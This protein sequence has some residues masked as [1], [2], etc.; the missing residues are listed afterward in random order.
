MHGRVHGAENTLIGLSYKDTTEKKLFD[1]VLLF[2]S[3]YHRLIDKEMTNKLLD[4][5]ILFC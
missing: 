5:S 3:I 4:I 1:G 2:I